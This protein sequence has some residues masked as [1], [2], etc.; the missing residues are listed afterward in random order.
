MDFLADSPIIIRID[1]DGNTIQQVLAISGTDGISVSSQNDV[2][3]V[4]GNNVALI[5]G[6][7]A[8]DLALSGVLQGEINAISGATI[9][10]YQTADAALSGALQSGYIAADV[11]LSGLLHNADVAIIS[12]YQAADVVLSGLLHNEVAAAISGADSAN[13]ALSG[14]LNGQFVHLTGNET[15]S[16][17]KQFLGNMTV[18]GNLNVSGSIN[19]V[20][21]EELLVEDNK[22]LLNSTWSG[23]PTQDAAIEVNR[24]ALPNAQLYWDEALDRWEF[25]VSGSLQVVASV[26]GYQAADTALSG[27]LHQEI[28]ASTS[29][30]QAADTALSG[31]LVSGYNGAIVAYSGVADNKF[32]KLAGD[33]MTGSLTVTSGQFSLKT[34][35]GYTDSNYIEVTSAIQTTDDTVTDIQN[36]VLSEGY[37]YWFESIVIGKTAS[38]PL[39]IRTEINRGSAYRIVAGSATLISSIDNTMT[40]SL[41][42]GAYDVIVDVS[43]NSLRVRVTGAIGN[44]VNW[45]A[46][47][48]YQKV[49]TNA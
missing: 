12:G 2:F 48:R 13:T 34:H 30:Y 40:R 38:G 43:G 49:G 17:D 1:A 41:S 39:K 6:Y 5:S 45:V 44:T 20:N 27:A 10:G 14:A 15:I 21:T 42:A 37:A 25:G 29:G 19:Q 11:V 16:G 8:A 4:S 31:A 23:S 26:S 47:L 7:Q 18:R 36:L 24:G 46:T 22:I 9:S 35:S 3:V 32:V 33:T 28:L